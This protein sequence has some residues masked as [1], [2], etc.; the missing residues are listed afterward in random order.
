VVAKDRA[1][2]Y[3]ATVWRGRTLYVCDRCGADS[4]DEAWI[5]EHVGE[6]PA[7]RR[8]KAATHDDGEV[9]E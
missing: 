8:A 5:R 4:F 1:K 7:P 6:H 9:S 2:G 3:T